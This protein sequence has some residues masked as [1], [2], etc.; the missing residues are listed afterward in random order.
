MTDWTSLA[1]ESFILCLIQYIAAIPWIA[2]LTLQ[3]ATDAFRAPTLKRFVPLSIAVLV[4]ASAL[5]AAGLN[6]QQDE[7][8]LHTAGRLYGAVLYV[9]L[10]LDFFVITLFLLGAVW[11]RGAAVAVA[12]FREGVRQP[13]FLFVTVVALLAMFVMPYIPYF[14]FGEDLKMVR[15]LGYDVIMLAAAIFAVLTASISISEEIEGRTAVTLMSKPVSRRQF[16][17]G[18]FTGILLASLLMTGILSVAYFFLLWYK[19][20]YDHDTV[21]PPMTAIYYANQ[22]HLDPVG[23]N[24]ATGI[25]WWFFDAAATSPGLVLGFCQVMVLLAIAVAL[26]TRLPMVVNLVVCLV[27]FF[28]GH[29]APV[30]VQ[31]SQSRMALVQF[32]AKFFEFALPSL[33][34][35]NIGP[36][37]TRDTPP[38]LTDFSIY[39]GSVAGY[40]LLYTAIALIFGLILFEDRDL[41]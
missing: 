31:A 6:Y 13:T 23:A 7:E 29:L 4:A 3:S 37:L 25:G 34:M 9:Q 16:L 27:V 12:A 14:T 11:R 35:F 10:M 20:Y 2:F 28:L 38:P 15:E 22:V 33:E 18:K 5:V 32:M 26:A 30:L 8:L 24:L 40:A 17:L 41:A 21:T 36:A 39:V 19:P 1:T